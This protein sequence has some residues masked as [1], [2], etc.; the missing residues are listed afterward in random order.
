MRVEYRGTVTV[1]GQMNAR[2]EAELLRDM[3]LVGPVV[4]T[5]LWP[6]T[7]LFEYKVT[8]GLSQPKI[9]P[10]YLV[11]KLVLLPFHPF[12]TIKELIP[13]DTST[14]SPPRIQ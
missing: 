11:P 1:D 7:K 14:N 2:V 12:R 5:V 3:W 9:E 10:L 8:G 6:V 13:E 4:S